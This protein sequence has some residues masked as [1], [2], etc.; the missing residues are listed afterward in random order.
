MKRNDYYSI[1]MEELKYLEA[2]LCLPYYNEISI[3]CQQ[4]A[5]KVLKS[6]AEMVCVNDIEIILKTHN[7]KRIADGITECYP[8]FNINVRDAAYLKDFYFDARYPGENYM[9]VTKTE[10]EAAL[11][12]M[13][14]II[15]E[16][17]RF[18]EINDLEIVQIECKTLL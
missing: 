9:V 3:H 11:E 1:A 15:K 18:R 13:Y 2:T 10:C 6:V 14:K 5:E 16:V 8:D 7:L 4:V 12:I 17:N